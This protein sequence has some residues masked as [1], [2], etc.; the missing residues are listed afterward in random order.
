M[1]TNDKNFNKKI[2]TTNSTHQPASRRPRQLE[3]AKRYKIR[4]KQIE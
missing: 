4:N 2:E 1:V 3:T